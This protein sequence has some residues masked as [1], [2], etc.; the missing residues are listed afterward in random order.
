MKQRC[1]A[2]RGLQNHKENDDQGV[3]DHPVLG[4]ITQPFIQQ[5]DQDGCNRHA[6]RPPQ[7]SQNHH[8]NDLKGTEKIESLR[9]DKL[10]RMGVE[11]TYYDPQIGAGIETLFR[12]NTTA[13]LVEAPGSQSFEMQ[14]IPAIAEVAH[15]RGACVVAVFT[16]EIAETKASEATDLGRRAGHPLTFTTEP[17]E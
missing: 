15:Q 7:P 14:D 13:V 16:R 3:D 5:R 1:Q 12:P 9:T 10:D 2:L 6:D 17:E 4:E 11:T 8:D